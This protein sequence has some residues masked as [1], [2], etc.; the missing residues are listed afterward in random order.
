MNVQHEGLHL[1]AAALV[2]IHHHVAKGYPDESCGA[3]IGPK[4]G[5]V[6][7]AFPLTNT[8]S[9]ER[10]RRFL[11]GPEE[12]RVAER[13][14]SDTGQQLLGFYHSHPDHPAVPSAFDLEHAWPNLSYLIVSVSKGQPAESRSWRL[15]ADRSG[16][17][18]EQI[19][20]S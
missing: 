12:Y 10:R 14:A 18:E 15:K 19:H 16:Y 13:R 2:E 11:V 17:D 6:V 7:E 8:T 20:H 5:E 9:L 4:Q 1:P 3:L